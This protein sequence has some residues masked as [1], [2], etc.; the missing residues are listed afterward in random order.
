MQN[1][2]GMPLDSNGYTDSIIQADT[3]CYLC[4]RGGETARHEIFEGRG[5]RDKC[6]RLGLWVRLCPSCHARVHSE[7]KMY[8][9]LKEDAQKAAM[10]KYGWDTV[11]FILEMGRNYL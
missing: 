4:G 6:K 11:R 7:P 1:E 3:R 10:D 9:P 2:Y 8:L 5:R